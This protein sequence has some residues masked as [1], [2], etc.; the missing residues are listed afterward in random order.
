MAAFFQSSCLTR[1]LQPSPH[2]LEGLGQPAQ[3]AQAE[4]GF[5]QQ[6]SLVGFRER[7][8]D[9]APRWLEE[10]G[11]GSQVGTERAEFPAAVGFSSALDAVEVNLV[12]R[13]LLQ[14]R[15]A[16]VG[17]GLVERLEVFERGLVLVLR[18]RAE[19]FVEP[20]VGR[21]PGVGL[22]RAQLPGEVF[23]QQRMR[24]ERD[25]RAGR[26]AV[27]REQVDFLEATECHVPIA[28][29]QP[30]QRLGQPGDD[31]RRAQRVQATPGR[32]AV[33]Q[34]EQLED[35]QLALPLFPVAREPSLV[36]LHRLERV[37]VG[38]GGI[39][40]IFLVGL[41]EAHGVAPENV[42]ILGQ[43]QILPEQL[44][45]EA[46]PA[47]FPA[48]GLQFLVVGRDVLRAGASRRCDGGTPR[49]R[50]R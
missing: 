39:V 19:V 3:G 12:T 14:P 45:R 11:D 42:A 44:Q 1:N 41:G 35:G 10:A 43:P 46:V 48:G 4:G 31:R 29:T 50:G 36:G 38:T 49:R 6:P 25:E 7:G 20:P 37:A 33:E 2:R 47:H 30:D 15:L 21:A 32:G 22:L 5:V 28:R 34:A 27:H 40:L 24:I 9:A 13:L 18:G 8:R 26:V 23:A 16:A 17:H